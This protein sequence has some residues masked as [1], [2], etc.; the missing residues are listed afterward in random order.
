[1]KS[2]SAQEFLPKMVEIVKTV[3]I[4]TTETQNACEDRLWIPPPIGVDQDW[5]ATMCSNQYQRQTMS[6][7][8]THPTAYLVNALATSLRL[9]VMIDEFNVTFDA[10][11]TELKH[12]RSMTPNRVN[13][14]KNLGSKMWRRRSKSK[15]A[16]WSTLLASKR[17]L[18]N[19]N[20]LDSICNFTLFYAK[21]CGE[22]LED[23]LSSSSPHSSSSAATIDNNNCRKQFMATQ[24]FAQKEN[25]ERTKKFRDCFEK[26]NDATKRIVLENYDS[27]SSCQTTYHK[28]F[29]SLFGN[30]QNNCKDSQSAFDMFL[31]FECCDSKQKKTQKNK[32]RRKKI[33]KKKGTKFP[34]PTLMIESNDFGKI[35][36]E[37]TTAPKSP[38]S[39][40]SLTTN[41]EKDEVT[42]LALPPVSSDDIN[43][44]NSP[45]DTPHPVDTAS[46]SEV[47]NE[48]LVDYLMQSCSI[49]AL[50]KYMDELGLDCP[51]EDIGEDRERS[52]AATSIGDAPPTT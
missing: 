30:V 6:R 16:E 20:V 42:T 36:E 24:I 3:E 43:T 33:K 23:D 8:K 52:R 34:I 4:V 25:R 35:Q 5:I 46:L 29:S 18:N 38:K 48:D 26:S 1:M 7:Y 22:Q 19:L 9:N 11:A 31:C 13:D 51:E 45:N 2:I 17:V 49:L 37:Q 44:V 41:Y 47:S 15:L 32:S 27:C 50:N 10:L 40:I 12:L 28:K 21:V 14:A 39:V